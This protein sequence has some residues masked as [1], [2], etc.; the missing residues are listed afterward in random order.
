MAGL[1]RLVAEYLIPVGSKL[2]A[3][4]KNFDRRWADLTLSGD[5]W[6]GSANISLDGVALAHVSRDL[7]DTN[8]VVADQQTVR[9]V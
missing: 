9:G 3:N 5:M 4:F 2:T 7:I 8:E 6:G 1:V